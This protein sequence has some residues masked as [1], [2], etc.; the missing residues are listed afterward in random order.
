MVDYNIT[1]LVS[2][3]RASADSTD[4]VLT[5]NTTDDRITLR[6]V[7]SGNNG[8]WMGSFSV[9]FADGTT[10]DRTA[11]R[12]AVVSYSDT[13][14]NDNVVGFPDNETFAAKAGNDYM[15]GGAGD[16]AYV[17]ARGHGQDT[18]DDDDANGSG[19][20]VR[21]TDINSTDVTVSRLFK[22]ST[23][24][25]FRY[26][27]DA[28]DSLTVLN[29]LSADGK[30]IEQYQ[31]ADGVTW[32]KAK[33][34][35][36]L[37]NA[38][39]IARDDGYFSAVS[40]Q[41]LTLT[42]ATILSN[43]FDPNN[44]SISIVAVDAGA[45]GVAVIDDH[46]D[47]VF[48][49]NADFT[50]AAPVT[51][52]ISDGLGGFA[53]ANINVRVRP[54]AEAHDDTGFTVAED[55]QLTI[56]VGRLLSNDVDGDRMV[57]GEVKDALHGTVSLSSDGQISFTPDL[58]YNGDAQFS[59]VANTPEGGSAQADV[60]ITVTPVNDPPSAH[61]DGGFSTLE[62]QTITIDPAQL[63]A[64]DTDVDGDFFTLVSV[65]PSLNIQ[66][67]IQEDGSILLTPRDYFF[68][69]SYFDYTIADS[70]G[71]TSTARVF[72]DV[73]KHNTAPVAADDFFDT[74]RGQPIL[75]NNPIV[76]DAQDLFANDVDHENDPLSII[77]VGN[78]FG[79]SARL[80][81]NGTVLF[82]PAAN[83]YGDASFDY[84]VS[85]G[86]LTST[87]TATLRYQFVNQPPV[88]VN[89]RFDSNDPS[90][91]IILRGNEDVPLEIP[92]S[93]LLKNDYDIEGGAITF[94]SVGSADHG[95]VVL[96]DHG[97]VIYTPDA[98]YYSFANF[99]YV[100]AD[101]SGSVAGGRV[102]LYFD[103]SSAD[104]PP[105]ANV[106]SFSVNEDVPVTIPISALLAN[107]ATA[108][109]SPVIFQGWF[110]SVPFDPPT[111]RGIL[112]FDENGDLGATRPIE[113]RTAQRASS[114]RSPMAAATRRR[115]K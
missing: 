113:T 6:D 8:S 19:D 94:E 2:A 112:R 12:Q 25:L 111:L 58:N 57:V 115:R 74:N 40:G 107:D 86:D 70:S 39:P 7:L 42:A 21:F 54:V 75:E 51:Y 26:Q 66:P 61:D 110:P 62:N 87:A 3:V 105:V 109:G 31:F 68:G 55:G 38:A 114:I 102:A 46:G 15:A 43:D 79:G 72:V 11:M 50:G 106:D 20:A 78:S 53:T 5:F 32:D 104:A 24:V 81:N 29:A 85:D 73:I 65:S 76:I 96:T 4:L 23:D 77:S 83:F 10:W 37:D 82:T 69:P 33:V 59:Y 63:L 14:G 80:L 45:N 44:D 103:P 97:T 60:H 88:A 101:L 9:R 108:Y 30:G 16:D 17:F 64:N 67:A 36:L 52:R 13:G 99:A 92:V 28:A 56:S 95:T 34:H 27:N 98:G 100:I 41:P 71:A 18:I 35:S 93:E 47:V 48:T 90:L 91:N 89:D 22:G 49:P 1:D 84:T